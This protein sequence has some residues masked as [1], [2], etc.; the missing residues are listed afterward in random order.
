VLFYST[1]PPP[2]ITRTL[3]CGILDKVRPLNTLA[4]RGQKPGIAAEH[5]IMSASAVGVT[6]AGV[7]GEKEGTQPYD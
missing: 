2:C 7:E 1:D 6:Q 4:I 3:A 5:L